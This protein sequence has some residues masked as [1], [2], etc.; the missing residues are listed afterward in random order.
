M[1]EADYP[2]AW[3]PDPGDS[4]KGTVRQVALSPDMGYGPYP[5]VTLDTPQGELAV[6]AFRS[7][8]RTELARCRPGVGDEIE[9]QYVGKRSPKSGK[10][11]EYHVYRVLG[12][13]EPEF[14]WTSELPEDERTHAQAAS[15]APPIQPAA[16]PPPV[17]APQAVTVPGACE[18]VED[19]DVPF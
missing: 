13:K 11:N 14:D 17:P 8:L 10:G 18:P 15:A 12:G 1:S 3:K 9:I 2:E 19:D 16:I 5:I 7:I 6:H 4:V